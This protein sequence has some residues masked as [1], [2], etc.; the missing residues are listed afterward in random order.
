MTTLVGRE[1][2]QQPRRNGSGGM[3][4]RPLRGRQVRGQVRQPCHG[5]TEVVDLHGPVHWRGAS[6]AQLT[7]LELTMDRPLDAHLPASAFQPRL[8]ALVLGIAELEHQQRAPLWP[9]R[10]A[11]ELHAGL[12]GCAPAFSDVAPQAGAN[13]VVP[14]G[15]ATA[16][17]GDHVVHGRAASV[18]AAGAAEARSSRPPIARIHRSARA[19]CIG[20]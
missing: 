18:A 1:G 9:N 6:A 17:A 11:V 16:A 10:L 19:W 2:L 12:L 7:P 3:A 15:L 8:P 20:R 14:S 13:H 4:R 5:S